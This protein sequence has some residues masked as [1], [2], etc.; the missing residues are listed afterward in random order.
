[1]VLDAIA[2]GL[3]K[4][5]EEEANKILEKEMQEL[6]EKSK[7]ILKQGWLD[8]LSTSSQKYSTGAT[9]DSFSFDGVKGNLSSGMEASI[10]YGAYAKESYTGGSRIPYLAVDKGW[11]FNDS[12]PNYTFM[13]AQGLTENAKSKIEAILPDY[14]RLEIGG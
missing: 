13:P 9:A 8:W 12:V 5:I 10:S 6:G 11:F 2:R 3:E 7:E 14:I 4:I 1:M